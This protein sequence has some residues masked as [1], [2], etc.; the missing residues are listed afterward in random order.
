MNSEKS[1]FL[2]HYNQSKHILYK[3]CQINCFS[4]K[5]SEDVLIQVFI[6]LNQQGYLKLETA[7]PLFILRKVL[8]ESVNKINCVAETHQP[9]AS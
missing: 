7:I 1:F 3:F 6:R 4:K 8:R 5:E 2:I 9:T